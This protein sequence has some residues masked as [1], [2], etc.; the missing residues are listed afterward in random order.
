MTIREK[1]IKIRDD[2]GLSQQDFAEKLE[3]SRQTVARWESGKSQ[4][5]SVQVIKICKEFGLDANALLSDASDLK[6]LDPHKD[7]AQPEKNSN[8]KKALLPAAIALLILIALI[9]FIIT[10]I[11]G[12]K[13]ASFD[14]TATV[15]IIA[16]PQ[17]TP[18]IVLSLF[19]G[20]FIILL[21]VLLI[22]LIKRGKK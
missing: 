10:I 20:A 16:V 15:W 19:L 8:V 9:G 21:T 1:L 4:P 3:V 17:N 11:Y 22:Y 7:D 2:S 12:V 18:M 5:S 13:D 6:E 14:T